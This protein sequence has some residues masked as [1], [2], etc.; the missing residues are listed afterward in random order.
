MALVA[1]GCLA[2]DQ[3]SPEIAF[4]VALDLGL[5]QAAHGLRPVGDAQLFIDGQRVDDK[6]LLGDFERNDITACGKDRMPRRPAA[7]H[8]SDL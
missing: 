8:G 5:E 2:H 1:A 6:L 3:E 4:A 7:N